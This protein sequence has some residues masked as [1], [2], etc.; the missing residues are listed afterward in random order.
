MMN[1]VFVKKFNSPEDLKND[2]S[3]HLK[4]MLVTDGRLKKN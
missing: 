1:E 2:F 4:N 3:N